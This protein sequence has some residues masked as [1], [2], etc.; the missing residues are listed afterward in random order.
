MTRLIFSRVCRQTR[1]FAFPY[2]REI[3]SSG[4][5]D[6]RG[7]GFRANYFRFRENRTPKPVSARRKLRNMAAAK[8]KISLSNE[9]NRIL[10]PFIGR[11][12][13]V[14]TSGR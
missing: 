14:D 8:L 4:D 2:A 5:S 9:Q 3:F 10:W 13:D 1:L 7:I 11:N 6:A 12:M